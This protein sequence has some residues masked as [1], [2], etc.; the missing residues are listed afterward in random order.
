[1]KP[2]HIIFSFVCLHTDSCGIQIM[3]MY[4][5]MFKIFGNENKSKKFNVFFCFC[6]LFN[7]VFMIGVQYSGNLQMRI[8]L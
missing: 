8:K 4:R 1:M 6:Y 2:K 3:Y 5:K 7:L